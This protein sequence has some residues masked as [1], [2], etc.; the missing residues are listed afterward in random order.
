MYTYF[1]RWLLRNGFPRNKNDSPD[2]PET[3]G[4]DDNIHLLSALRI[5]HTAFYC[6]LFTDILH[7]HPFTLPSTVSCSQ[8]FY[9]DI[10]SHCLLLYP[11]HRHSTSTSVHTAFY[12]ILFT[13]ILHRH[14]FTLPSTVSCSQTFYIDIRSHCLLLYPVHRHST[15]T[16]VHTAFYSI[17]FTDILHRHPFTLP[18]TVSCSQ[19]FY[20]DIRSHC[21]L[22]YPVHRHSTSTS[23]HTA[24]Y[25]IL[26]TDILHRHPFTLPSTAS[27]SQ[28][29]YINIR[30]HCLLLYPVHRHSTSTSVHTA[31]YCILF[32]GILHQHPFTLPSTVSCSQTFYIDIRSHCLLLYP[33]H[34][35]STSTSVHTAFYCILFTDILHQHPFTLP[36]TVS[37]SQTFYIDIRSHCLLL[38]PVHRHSTSTSVHTAFY[39]ILFTDIL[40]RHPFTLPSTVP[41]SQTFYID[42]RS[43]CLLLYPV[44]RHSTSAS[45]H[46]AFYCILFT[47]ILH[48]HPFTLPSTVSC[49]QTFYIDIRSHCL[50]LYPVHR[51]ST[52]TSVHTAFYCILFTDILHRHPFTLPSTVSCSQTF[53]IDI[54]S[55]CLLLYPV[56]R[57]STSTSVH[58]AFYCI[59]FTDIL[60]QHPFTLPSTVSCSQTFYIDIRS[61]CLLLYPVHRHSTSASFTLPSTVSCSDILHRHPFTLPSTVPCSQTFYIDIRSHCLLLYPVHR[62]STSASFTLPSTV[63]CSQ[64]FYIDI[65]SHCLLLYPVHRHSTSTSVHTAFYCILFTDILHR[66]PF[67]LPSTV[68]CSQTFYIDIRSHCLL[69]YPVHRHSTSTSVHTAFYCILFTDILHQHRS[70]CLLL[71][72]VHRHSTSTSVHTAFYCILF[73]DIL[74]RHPFTLPSTVSCSQTFYISI[75]HTAFYCILF[76][77]ILHRHPFTLPSTVSCSQTFYIDIRSHCLLLYPVHRHSTSTSVHTAFYCILFTDILHR[78]PFTLPSTV[79]CS[80][81]FYIDIR[82]HCLLLYPVHRHSTSTS[83]HTAFYCILFTGILH[84]HPFTLP[85]TVSC[86]QTFYISIRS[87]FL[88]LYPVQTFYIDIRSHCLLLYPVHRHSTSTSVHTA[89]Y[90]ILFTDILHRHPF[91]LPSTVSC[92]QTFYIDIRSHCLLLYPVHR[93]STSTSVHTA[94][95]CILFTGILHRHPF[96]L[97]S[98]VSCSQTFYIDIRSHCLLL[99]PVHRLSTSTSVHTSFYCILFT[100]ILHRQWEWPYWAVTSVGVWPYWS[101]TSVEVWPYWAVISVGVW[102]YWAVT[103][104]GVWPY[105]AVTSVGVWPYW[106]VTSV[107]V[108]LLGRHLSGSGL[109]GRSPQW[110][111]P[112]WAVTSVWVALSGHHLSG[113]VALLGR[114]L[115][116]SVALLGRHLSGSGLI[117]P[118]PQWECG[119]IGRS[120]QWEWPYRAVTS[121]GVWPY[122]AVTSV[123]V[124]PYWAVTSVGVWPYWAVT[125]VGVWPY[126]AVTSVG[127]ALLGRHLSGSGLIGRSPQWEWPYWAVTSVGVALSGHHLS[128]SVAILGRHLSG[129]VALLGRYLSGSVALL[130]RHLSG[131]VALLGRHLS[132]SGLIGP[133]PQWECGLIGRS[134]QW[135]WP[136]WAVTSAGVWPYWAVTSVGVWPY[137]A[138]TSA[139]VW[140]YWAITSVGVA[141]LG[142]FSRAAGEMPP[143]SVSSVSWS[144][145]ISSSPAAVFSSVPLTSSVSSPETEIRRRLIVLLSRW[146]QCNSPTSCK[147]HLYY[148]Y[149]SCCTLYYIFRTG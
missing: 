65:H 88:V 68:S 111:W 149:S 128:G 103:S 93:H 109:I 28:T 104:V 10:R 79:S 47:D 129:S 137:W 72:P 13:D 57:H 8:T 25:C 107:G 90:C 19:T 56:H 145:S 136:Y 33:V 143:A 134:P 100:D 98:T 139:G 99:Y 69:L 106:A 121:V 84:R 80:Q 2:I 132:G 70:H 45:V 67:T 89:F 83:V 15:S 49:S 127:V 66:H 20:I 81:T 11:V 41:C 31:F 113:S 85:S 39:C 21:L 112:Y 4:A 64:T 40:H 117:G 30:S 50:L 87:H 43:H 148:I 76:T 54:R 115:S 38:Y 59:L 86:S 27:C 141:L 18:S 147:W 77:D 119:L 108:A 74:H 34:R 61:H 55:H 91:T 3:D 17:L 144:L 123:G 9:I 24:F 53:Y 60:H 101:I 22:L 48:Q 110:E 105:W 82:S 51:H 114:H 102:P 58:T 125:S 124:W 35:H 32:T 62:H 23:V 29:F 46:T 92:S 37:C 146:M 36:S 12:C 122:W 73:T 7:R 71:Y 96:T 97:P 5:V 140:P 1:A 138:V 95:Y 63:S 42:I 94:F 120:P 78:H 126:W 135:E 131:S 75:V 14:P 6:I 44:H 116:G 133:S 130:G 16:S 142:R 26:F 52:S 118:S